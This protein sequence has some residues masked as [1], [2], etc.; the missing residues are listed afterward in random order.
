MIRLTEHKKYIM[1][2]VAGAV[3]SAALILSTI[4]YI[5]KTS[6]IKQDTKDVMSLSYEITRD[7]LSYYITELDKC[8]ARCGEIPKDTIIN[9]TT[10]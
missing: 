5:S 3:V 2:M 6:A 8:N 1:A 9:E 7:K 4:F 10:K